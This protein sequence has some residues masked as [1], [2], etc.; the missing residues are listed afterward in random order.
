M[1]ACF[2]IFF[3]PFSLQEGQFAESY[4]LVSKKSTPGRIHN[5]LPLYYITR[6]NQ[7]PK[8]HLRFESR[9]P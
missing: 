3:F 5:L 6:E 7:N 8:I 1:S 4:S 2:D 9:L